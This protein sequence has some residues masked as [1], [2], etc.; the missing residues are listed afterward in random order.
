MSDGPTREQIRDELDRVAQ[1]AA[2][3]DVPLPS[4]NDPGGAHAKGYSADPRPEA[5]APAE[6]PV[7]LAAAPDPDASLVQQPERDG[8]A[9][10]TG[11][12][13][14]GGYSVNDRL[15]GSDR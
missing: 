9:Q 2:P 6:G 1:P 4:T 13:Q 14:P 3:R 5:P 10:P 7:P 8:K 12:G 11:R 15:M